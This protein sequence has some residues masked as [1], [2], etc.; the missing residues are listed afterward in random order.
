MALNT[1]DKRAAVMEQDLPSPDGNID[2]GDRS[3]LL[4]V[5][6]ANIDQSSGP[7]F[8]GVGGI[9]RP[10]PLAIRIGLGL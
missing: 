3:Q 10:Q 7:P 1:K 9:G 5:S 4:D 2:K 8:S 6:R